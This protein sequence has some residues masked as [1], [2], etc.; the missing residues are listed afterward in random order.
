MDLDFALGKAHEDAGDYAASFD[1]YSKGNALHRARN[2]YDAN[3][4]TKRV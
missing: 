4:N 2:R 1:H 3:L